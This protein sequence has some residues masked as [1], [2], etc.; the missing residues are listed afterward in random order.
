[1]TSVLHHNAL[2]DNSEDYDND[3]KQVVKEALEDVVLF[4]SKLSTVDFIEDLHEDESME[5]QSEVLNFI[6]SGNDFTFNHC[7]KWFAVI[8][9][10]T[11]NLFT[12][13]KH[14]DKD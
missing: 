14:G 12:S 8:V 1:M 11:E 3:E 10:I 4:F 9:F 13:K 7:V 2:H 6:N 5:D